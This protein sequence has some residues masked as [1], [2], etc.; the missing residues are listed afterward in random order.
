MIELTFLGTGSGIASLKRNHAA[1]VLEY[2]SDERDIIL[3]DCGEGTQLQFMKSGI[4][5][6]KV[7]KI[8]I[9][10][11]HADHFSGLIPLIQT[12]NMEGR[13]RPLKIIGPE[14][15]RFVSD[16]LDLGYFGMRFEVVA[17]DVPYTGEEMTKV[18]ETDEYEIFSIPVFPTVPAVGYVFKEKEKWTIDTEKMKKMKLRKGKWL[19]DLKKEGKVM[20]KGKKIKI[21]DI[22]DLKPGLTVVYS[23]DTKPSENVVRA[24][25]GAD[26]L[27]HD[28]TFLEEEEG[29]AHA[30]VSQAAT[31]AKKAGVKQLI[32]T[33][34]SRRYNTKKD[35]Y[36]IKKTA[37]GIF[38]NTNI[39]YDGM[40]V[41]LKKE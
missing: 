41:K 31:I 34:L 30:D 29:K 3:F 32:I 40:K 35:V 18:D 14:A 4:S 7:D 20:Y 8:F 13:E 1:I 6:M 24:A 10:H 26:L 15:E 5:F 33:H 9:T 2:S 12:M 19:K 28:G 25:K 21:Q 39:A 17:M 23:G 38:L 27:I 22:A 37:Q 36:E 16:I 11:W